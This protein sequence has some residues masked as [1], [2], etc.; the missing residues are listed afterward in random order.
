MAKIIF[1]WLKF[2]LK[3][4]VTLCGPWRVYLYASGLI[5]MRSCDVIR[6]QRYHI[7]GCQASLI[8]N[9]SRAHKTYHFHNYIIWSS[10]L[11]SSLWQLSPWSRL[12]DRTPS[13]MP[14]E[15]WLL[16]HD[17]MSE[18]KQCLTLG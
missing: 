14:P 5:F 17:K 16:T 13:E 9:L 1:P 7:I 8:S 4:F 6:E 3:C 10:I 11:W 2:W 15:S 18:C 12:R